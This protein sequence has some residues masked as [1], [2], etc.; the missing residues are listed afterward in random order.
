M[1]LS[2]LGQALGAIV[3]PP[4]S[5]IKENTHELTEREKTRI[6]AIEEKSRKLG[7]QVKIRILYAGN[8]ETIARQRMQSLVGTFKQY[9]TANLNGFQSKY[10]S[11]DRMKVQD[12]SNRSFSDRGYI[13]N[14]EELASI[15]HLP[16]T[17]I[18]TPNIAWATTKTAEPP[19][20]LPTYGTARESEISLFGITNFRSG[21]EMFGALRSDRGKHICIAGQS[22]SGKSG[23]LELLSLSDIYYKQ[24]LA[25][26]DP[27][28]DYAIN[29]LRCIPKDRM[30]DVIYFNPKDSEFPIGFNPLEVSDPSTKGQVCTELVSILKN[31]FESWGPRLEYILRYSILALLDYPQA[32]LLDI[33][34]LIKDEEF[35][36]KVILYIQDPLVKNFWNTEHKSWNEKFATDTIMPLL[37][38]VEA[39]TA[40]PLLRNI[41]GQP[42][43]A[44][45]FRQAIDDGKIIIANLSLGLIGENNTAV[46]GAL[47]I[48]RIQQ[49]AMHSPEAAK[50]EHKRPFYLYIDEFQIFASDSFSKL[51]RD[52]HSYN[53]NVT[54]ANQTLYQMNETVRKTVLENIDTKIC[55]RLG[56]EDSKILKKYFAPQFGVTDLS[57]LHDRHFVITM[58][59]NGEKSVA[60]SATTLNIPEITNDQSLIEI[61]ALSRSKYATNK[62]QVEATL[63]AIVTK[64]TVITTAKPTTLHNS[65]QYLS[66]QNQISIADTPQQPER[67]ST[68]SQTARAIGTHATRTH[69]PRIATAK[70]RL[71]TTGKLSDAQK[72]RLRRHKQTA[73]RQAIAS[74]RN[75]TKNSSNTPQNHKEQKSTNDDPTELRIR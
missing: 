66:L 10:P 50:N 48:S 60:F 40:H 28:G 71:N 7:Y 75:I 18:E 70:N 27:H 2:Y 8:D 67:I 54:I 5:S 34:R 25:I 59:I 57:Q 45:N 21:N 49:A 6:S 36:N 56:H 26:I 61:I 33:T 51:F 3:K 16:H 46:L 72:Q 30:G 31:L 11:F 47:L 32:T 15:F 14:I 69:Q 23:M 64:D 62:Q 42:K 52:T 29:I 74:S 55:F 63:H 53:L 37:Q 73:G 1:G 24:G 13:L 12:Y 22:G 17:S 44:I 4:E 9:N 19:N 68:P 41:F 58:H 39:F 20:N 35:R 65:P 38:T 43:N